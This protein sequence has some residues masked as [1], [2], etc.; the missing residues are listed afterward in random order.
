MA[1]P[2]APRTQL[3]TLSRAMIAREQQSF[4]L[5][6]QK[7]YRASEVAACLGVHVGTVRMWIAKGICPAVRSG[8]GR[9]RIAEST[10]LELQGRQKGSV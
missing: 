4:S 6:S 8:R 10:L 5:L 1:S 9:Y 7:F 2:L 3:Q